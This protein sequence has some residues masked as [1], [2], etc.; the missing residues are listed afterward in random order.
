MVTDVVKQR[1]TETATPVV[2]AIAALIAKAVGVDDPDTIIYLALAM[3]F[4]P[5]MITWLVVLVRK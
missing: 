2:F 5:A 4:V 3:S 1:P